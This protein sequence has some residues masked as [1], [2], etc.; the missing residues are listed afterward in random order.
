MK[1]MWVRSLIAATLGLCL[2]TVPVASGE[3]DDF[4]AAVEGFSSNHRVALFYLRTG[5]I[6]LAAVE[7][8][9]MREAWSVVVDRFSQPPA[10]IT[11][12]VL[13]TVTLTDM[14]TRMI[15]VRMVLDM[16][17]PD[18]AAGALGEMRGILARLRQSSGI[19][20]LADCVLDA[21][22]AMDALFGLRNA[23]LDAADPQSGNDILVQATR[24]GDELKRCE[25]IASPRIRANPEFRRLVDGALAGLAGLPDAVARR[26]SELLGRLLDELRAFDR[27]LAFRFG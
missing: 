9:R 2:A 4:N 20:V 27:L 19:V 3:L 8:D 14:A 13:Y 6:D 11:D 1:L 7:L 18:V 23:R 21:N 16:G 17:R 24:Y 26:D 10:P 22:N 5:N 25:T 12:R 15:G